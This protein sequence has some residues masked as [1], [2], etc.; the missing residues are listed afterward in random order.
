M[1]DVV[2]QASGRIASGS[3]LFEV[4]SVAEPAKAHSFGE[5]TKGL[6]VGAA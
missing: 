6:R 5:W 3:S 1:V 4:W 2:A